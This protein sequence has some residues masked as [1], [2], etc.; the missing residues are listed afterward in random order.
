MLLHKTRK[1]P[2][3]R[4]NRLK[5]PWD[6]HNQKFVL[7]KKVGLG[8]VYCHGQKRDYLSRASLAARG[9]SRATKNR[10]VD[11]SLFR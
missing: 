11:Y 10:I 7:P 2:K 5:K 6:I 1:Q 9:A 4:Q 8:Y 3:F